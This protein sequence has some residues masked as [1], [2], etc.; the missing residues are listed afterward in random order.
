MS[1]SLGNPRGRGRDKGTFIHFDSKR[2][3]AYQH[4]AAAGKLTF[5]LEARAKEQLSQI[6]EPCEGYVF[7]LSRL[8]LIDSMGM[9][10]LIHFMKT[11]CK[12]NRRMT[13]VVQDELMRELLLIARLDA[14]IP[15]CS[16]LDEAVRL[17]KGD[18]T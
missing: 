18:G 8:T 17:L 10:I 3:G 7:D 9:G 12:G 13:I 6:V 5:G 14:L 2:I 11:Y 1:G 15:L 4:I 16:T